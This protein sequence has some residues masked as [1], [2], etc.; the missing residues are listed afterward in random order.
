MQNGVKIGV[1]QDSNSCHLLFNI[2][3]REYSSE[4]TQ[5]KRSDYA[6]KKN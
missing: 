1:I 6:D 5:N 4:I 2:Q 3:S